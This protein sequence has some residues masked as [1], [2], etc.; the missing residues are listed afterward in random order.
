MLLQ[1]AGRVTVNTGSRVSSS[2]KWGKRNPPV[3]VVVSASMFMSA[4]DEC[5]ANENANENA[6]GRIDMEG[7]IWK[8]EGLIRLLAVPNANANC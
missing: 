7:V 4:K 2:D 3:A 5:D 1:T 6:S 8:V